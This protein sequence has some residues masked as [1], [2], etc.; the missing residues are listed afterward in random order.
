MDWDVSK[1]LNTIYGLLTVYGLRVIA[2]V[3][4]FIVGRWV[5]MGVANLVKRI[6]LKSKVDETLVSFV[7]NLSYI[8][9]L[10]FVVI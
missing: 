5:A 7:R 9:M 4:I 2:A 1:L 8:A 10:A 3:V 6:M